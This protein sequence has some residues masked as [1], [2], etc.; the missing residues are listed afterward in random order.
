MAER[1]SCKPKVM[2]SI[3]I[4]G[5]KYFFKTFLR[6]SPYMPVKGW[7]QT[8]L[9]PWKK[10]KRDLKNILTPTWFEHAAFWSGVRRATVAP[11]S[12][13]TLYQCSSVESW[14]PGLHREES[15]DGATNTAPSIQWSGVRWLVRCHCCQCWLFVQL[16]ETFSPR[17]HTERTGQA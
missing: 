2:S 8:W 5:N 16:S 4:G 13:L 15:C 14:E 17:A 6:N 11:R 7:L 9:F 3:L 1:W 10:V 12:L